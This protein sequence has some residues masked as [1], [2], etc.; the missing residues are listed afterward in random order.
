[1]GSG[2][3]DP[4]DWAAYSTTTSA[5]P[6]DKIFTSTAATGIHPDLNP[7]NIKA[8]ESCDSA[9]NPKSHP[10]ILMSDVTGSMGHLAEQIIKTELGKIMLEIYNRKPVSDPHILIGATGDATCDRA[11]LQVT[12]FEADIGIT[13]QIEKFWIEGNGGGNDGESY[14]LAWYFAEYM[15]ACDAITKRG[16]KG[17]LFT[18]GDEP[19]L[20]TLREQDIRKVFGHSAQGDLTNEALLEAVQ[21]HW[22]V[23]HLIVKPV[24]D[25]E[26]KWKDLLG[27][28]AISLSDY[29]KMGEVIVSTMQVIAG[30]DADVVASSWSGDTSLVVRD[31]ITSL[32]KSKAGGADAGGVH[33]F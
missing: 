33:R 17:F 19:P 14:N 5:K 2:R 3:F 4:K 25:S 24:N 1:M 27:Q 10:I 18:I 32:A 22:N 23:F 30:E 7:L 12:Q 21:Q 6:A 8:R 20:K 26:R 9:I 28:H 31:A 13:Q 16:E 15:T 11:P 29:T